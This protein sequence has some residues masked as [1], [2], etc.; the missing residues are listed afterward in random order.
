MLRDSAESSLP[1]AL[2]L[3]LG[4]PSSAH[5]PQPGLPVPLSH[6]GCLKKTSGASFLHFPL[7]GGFPASDPRPSHSWVELVLLAWACS[8][9][10]I[11]CAKVNNLH[12][13]ASSIPPCP[14]CPVP[15]QTEHGLTAI[16]PHFPHENKRGR[17]RE[18]SGCTGMVLSASSKAQH[19]LQHSATRSLHHPQGHTGSF[20]DLEGNKS[21]VR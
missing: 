9:A 2:P 18:A 4:K 8:L 11:P 16:L 20:C 14:I 21:P 6:A 15:E 13:I 5:L 3:P 1:S 10:H 12:S 19:F 7:Y 17:I